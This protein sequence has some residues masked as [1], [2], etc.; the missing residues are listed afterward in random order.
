MR[1]KVYITRKMPFPAMDLISESCDVVFHEGERNARHGTRSLSNIA[2]KDGIFCVASDIMDK[3]AIDK[4]RQSE[5][6]QYHERRI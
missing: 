3:R 2:D 4:R 6:H 5:D 1:P